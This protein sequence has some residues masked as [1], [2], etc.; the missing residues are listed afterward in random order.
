MDQNIINLYDQYIHGGIT[1][2]AFLDRLAKMAGGSAAALALLPILENDYSQSPQIAPSDERLAVERVHYDAADAK[3]TA[4]L[5]RLKGDRKRPGVIV[6]HENRGLN[7]HI[8]DVTRRLAVEGF[9]ALAPD[10]LSPL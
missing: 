9:L 1:R 5:A 6:I 10:M 4:Y 7:P 3:M 2:R 8:E